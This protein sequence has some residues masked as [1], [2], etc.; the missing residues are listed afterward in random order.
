MK[1]IP[2]LAATLIAATTMSAASQLLFIGT[3]TPKESTSRGIYAVRFDTVTG[4][5]SEPVLAAETPNP[6]FLALNPNGQV[7][8][9]L[10]DSKPLTGSAGGAAIAFKIDPATA[11]LSPL[12][13]QPTGGGSLAHIGI[14][15]KGGTLV[16]I[17]YG[18]GQI[19]SFPVA[20]DGTI[21]PRVSS[22]VSTGPLGPNKTRQDTP[23]PH[24]VTYSPDNR[25]AYVCDLGRDKIIRYRVD[26]ATGTLT[27]DGE[28]VAAAGDGPRHSKFS[29]DGKNFYVIN[30]LA[31]TIT[32]YNCDPA[33]GALTP[34][35]TVPT[36]PENFEGAAKN[37]TAEI[38]IH[39]NGLFVYGSNR[40]HDSIAVFSR[41]PA[42]GTL[43][44]IQIVPSGGGHPRNF[45]LS[46]DGRWLICANRDSDNLV[47]FK[48]D[49]ITGQL[50][51]NGN[52]AKVPQA[53]CVLFMPAT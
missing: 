1:K 48:V 33:T 27:P 2:L 47:V 25:F 17:S 12:N 23:H 20:A 45:N 22:F 19:T 35:Q 51:P 43:K 34:Q 26:S 39:P 18:G 30:E 13:A 5:L 49:E 3:Y 8:Y 16:T 46:P 4:V 42:D 29:A 21:K 32:L 38:R 41:N 28:F 6:T 24:S 50:T 37:T 11:K 31:G 40:G 52:K 14:D 7:L 15:A 53:V 9:A 36:L 10:G 44:R